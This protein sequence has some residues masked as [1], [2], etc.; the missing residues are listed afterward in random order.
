LK[1]NDTGE[2]LAGV[3]IACKKTAEFPVYLYN[4]I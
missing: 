4:V 2:P 1:D 3:R